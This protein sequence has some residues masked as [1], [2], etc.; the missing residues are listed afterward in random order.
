ME[1]FT[2]GGADTVRGYRE[3]RLVSDT[4][5][6]ASVELRLPVYSGDSGDFELLAAPFIDYGYASNRTGADPLRND[7]ASAGVG[8]LGTLFGRLDFS[9]YYGHAFQDF[10]NGGDDIQDDGFSFRLSARLL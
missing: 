3:S 6:V 4:G 1:Q 8:L 9:L 2:V 7:I 10:D 5:F